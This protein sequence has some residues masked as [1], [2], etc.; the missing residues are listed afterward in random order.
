MIRIIVEF[1]NKFINLQLF[2]FGKM[3]KKSQFLEK[4]IKNKDLFLSRW[5]TDNL[6]EMRSPLIK[7]R[8]VFVKQTCSLLSKN[9]NVLA[10]ILKYEKNGWQWDLKLLPVG[11]LTATPHMYYARCQWFCRRF[12]ASSA[13]SGR[14]KN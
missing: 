4:K 11:Y 5:K 7:K 10:S 12:C 13:E 3:E 8:K 6:W 2:S 9:K 14:G 1:I